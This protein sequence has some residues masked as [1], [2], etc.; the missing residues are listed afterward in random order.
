[1][2]PNSVP[3]SVVMASDDRYAM[4]LTVAAYSA[5]KN[6]SQN[7]H[8]D[9]YILDGGITDDSKRKFTQSLQSVPSKQVT[10]HWIHPR[11][12][13][14]EEICA[15]QQTVNQFPLSNYYRLILPELLPESVQKLI[16]LDADTIVLNDL[17]QLW[18]MDTGKFDFM[19]VQEPETPHLIGCFQ[20]WNAHVKDINLEDYGI[21]PE[22]QYCNAGLM[23]VNLQ[24][25]RE[26]GLMEDCL[27]LLNRYPF[28]FADQDALNIIGAGRWGNLDPRWN[29][30][31]GFYYAVS[32]DYPYSPEML[33]TIRRKPYVMHFTGHRK[34]WVMGMVGDSH[35]RADLFFQYYRET[36]WSDWSVQRKYWVYRSIHTARLLKQALKQSLQQITALGQPAAG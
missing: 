26:N 16:Y 32:P 5:V 31:F 1:M 34:P 14:L 15:K 10:I 20:T 25:C 33:E 4:P 7:H 24:Q 21:V 13:R 36:A 28:S 27:Q 35:P 3:V 9:L 19:A 23:L 8:M 18:S 12:A 17:S 11:S 2:A 29:Q 6:F 30:T 22:H